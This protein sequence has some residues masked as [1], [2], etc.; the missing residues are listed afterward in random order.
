MYF[1][2]FTLCDNIRVIELAAELPNENAELDLA[3]FLD[4]AILEHL[5]DEHDSILELGTLADIR[6]CPKDG[7]IE[8]TTWN[9]RVAMNHYLFY[10]IKDWN[11]GKVIHISD[12]FAAAIDRDIHRDPNEEGNEYEADFGER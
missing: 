10:G 3:I 1:D 9:G 5:R 12:E 11:L 4:G 7:E 6:L 2:R 8:L